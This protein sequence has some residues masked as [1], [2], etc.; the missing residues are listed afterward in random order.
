MN[1]LILGDNLE[2]LKSLE[3]ESVDLIYLDP[4]FFSNRNYEVI[5]G[6]KGE[7]R[8]FED[9]WSGGVDHYIDW[10]K[11]RVE[12]MHRILKPT[13]SIFLHCDDH[14]N[15]YIR[16]F[17]L[18]KIFGESN[19][20]SELIWKRTS[21]HNSAKRFPQIH[22]TIYFF[23]KTINYRFNAIKVRYSDKYAE[24]F[25]YQDDFGKY[26]RADLTGSGVRNGLSGDVWKGYNPTEKGRHWA[27]P[28]NLKGLFDI[29]AELNLLEILDF[30]DEKGVIIHAKSK[31]SL[32]SYKNYESVSQGKIQQS[33]IDDIPPIKGKE[34]I[35][36]P[37]QKPEALL[38]RIIS[39]ASNE[40]DVILDPFV[41]GGTT[42]AVA[43]KL[44]RQWIGIDQSVQAVKVSEMRLQKQKD[45][46]SAPFS[47]HLH[48]YDYDTLRY[49]DAFEF[50]TWIV[51]QYG[52]TPNTK[53]RG[54]FGTDGK[55]KEG[56]PIQVKRS[57]NVGRNVVDNF[58]SA[59]Q[60]FDKNLFDR[61]KAEQKPVGVLIAFSF[62]KGAIQEVAR[63]K[64]Q[65]GLMI[66]LVTVEE[67]VPIAKKPKLKLVFNDLGL[68]A[69]GLREIEFIATGE[70]EAGIE[71]YA[72]NFAYEAAAGFKADVMIDKEGKQVHKFNAGK[73]CIA[74]K[75]VD[76]Q[77]LE[78]LETIAL[79]VN[80]VVKRSS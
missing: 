67:F 12:E 9:R 19:F 16:V 13:G 39:C 3:S 63:L 48:K 23:S 7:V 61:L 22:D 41:G 32:P 55:T 72:W 57:D 1:R 71:F 14:A 66:Q 50:E 4:P 60:R 62:G 73:H 64:N 18:D 21:S 80:G 51:K 5:W 25:K 68:D 37:T 46:F 52:G 40:G 15:A 8:S 11:V 35:G 31:G 43:E 28:N 29:P 42:V 26:K 58:Y 74:V 27:T 30:L 24:V 20:R 59:I 10:L 78:S 38:E 36:Y 70:S 34:A 53:Q 49:S 33:I 69:K 6:D 77:G 65:E 75:V 2:I 54:D 56:V 17:V 45:L 76:N 44:K 79:T 47:L